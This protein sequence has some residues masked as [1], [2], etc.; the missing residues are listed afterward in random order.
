MGKQIA[1]HLVEALAKDDERRTYPWEMW[2]NGKWWHLEQG[3]TKDF[4][5]SPSSFKVSAKAWAKKHDYIPDV[6]LTQ[7]G[8]GVLLRFTPD[9]NA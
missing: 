1:E 2:T 8:E 3:K 4:D 5:V 7:D 9:P 6:R